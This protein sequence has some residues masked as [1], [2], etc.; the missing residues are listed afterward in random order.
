MGFN[1]LDNCPKCGKL[2][3]KGIRDV[4]SDCYKL[5]EEEYKKVNAYLK[6]KENRQASLYEVSEATAVTVKQITKFIR[7]GRISLND[8]PN[9]GLPCETCGEPTKTGSICP[10]CRAKLTKQVESFVER[11]EKR[12]EEDKLK[13]KDI[14]YR[15]IKED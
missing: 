11:E 6:K 3:V 12:I 13:V 10:A 9:M 8:L 4:C 14:G 1:Q 7:Q 5:E 15:H 2:F